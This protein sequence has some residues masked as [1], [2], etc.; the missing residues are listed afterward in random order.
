M[1]TQDLGITMPRDRVIINGQ[2]ATVIKH[3]AIQSEWTCIVILD[4][5]TENG[6]II[7]YTAPSMTQIV[8]AA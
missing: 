5:T 4:A 1:K 2:I 6:E 3:S 7:T 8:L